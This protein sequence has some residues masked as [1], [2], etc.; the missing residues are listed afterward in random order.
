MF[1][2]LLF[3]CAVLLATTVEAGNPAPWSPGE[4]HDYFPKH[5]TLAKPDFGGKLV[6]PLKGCCEKGDADCF[7]DRP[8][9]EERVVC[10]VSP[11]A[12]EHKVDVPKILAPKPY[13]LG[14]PLLE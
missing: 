11:K 6:P 5:W 13:E 4:S 10:P 3:S 2:V 14:A 7:A 9:G 12:G 1:F 8:T